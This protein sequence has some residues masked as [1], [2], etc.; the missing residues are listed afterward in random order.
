M[1]CAILIGRK[2][3]KGFPGKNLKKINGK[4]MCEYPLLAA[5]RTKS[6]GKIFVST[7][8]PIIKKISKKYNATILERPK[9]LTSSKALG[10][11]VF[12]NAYFQIKKK[13]KKIK[14]VV[15]LFANAPLVT[16]KMIEA[17][18]KILNKNKKCDSA[19]S[20]S[21]YNMWSPLRA[22]KL[23]KNG[24]LKPF[25]PFET[26]GNPKTL[27]CDRDS[28][29]TVYY[30][31]M[32]VSIVRPKCL[33]NIKQGLLPQKWMGSKIAPIFSEGGCDVDYEY[34]I[35]GVEHWLKKRGFK[36]L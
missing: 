8:C 11:H 14:Y 29:G 35:P 20:T 27:N 19:V 2:G 32:S 25:V 17:G 4:R 36:K 22:R 13:I 18:I 33:E 9:K 3:S 16:S 26:F 34:Q 5:K 1:I 21:V 6:I 12:E 23:T 30:A 15:L 28:Q 7:D 10:D 24:T 31:D